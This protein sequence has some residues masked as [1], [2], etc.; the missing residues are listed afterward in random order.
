MQIL[1]TKLDALTNT[2]FTYKPAAPKLKIN[3][4]T[5]AIKIEGEEREIEQGFLKKKK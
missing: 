3:N 4:S 5:P 2:H 1:N